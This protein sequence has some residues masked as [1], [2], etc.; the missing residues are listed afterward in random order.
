M[1]RRAKKTKSKSHRRRSVGA[2]NPN[3]NLVKIGAVAA[4]YFLGTK[5]NDAISKATGDKIDGKIIAA[6][7]AGLGLFLL[8][9]K[10]RKTMVTT[11]AGGVLAGS[12]VKK[13]LQEFG[14]INGYSDVPVLGG[15]QNVPVISGY[16]TQ[17]PAIGSY[18][19]PTPIHKTVMG[20]VDGGSGINTSDR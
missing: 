17:Q 8:M 14:V 19:V 7:E 11:I 2:I 15:Y 20:G 5:I 3:N 4:G 10:G 9:R 18:N 1:A 13:G 12:G 6:V 16:T